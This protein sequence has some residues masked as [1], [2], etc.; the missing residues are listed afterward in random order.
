VDTSP[1]MRKKLIDNHYLADQQFTQVSITQ[2][3]GL[4]SDTPTIPPAR[5]PK[6]WKYDGEFD[7][8]V[9]VRSQ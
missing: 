6:E 5:L 1:T 8:S 9:G 3:T 4:F 2:G 7:L